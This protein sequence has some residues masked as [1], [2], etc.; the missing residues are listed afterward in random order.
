MSRSEKENNVLLDENLL[1]SKLPH[2]IVYDLSYVI[3]ILEE[4]KRALTPGSC[5]LL[6]GEV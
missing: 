5:L 2:H 6:D 4:W 3:V 1:E